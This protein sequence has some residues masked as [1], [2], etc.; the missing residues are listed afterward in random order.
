MPTRLI[1]EGLRS[2]RPP[3][4]SMAVDGAG[5]MGPLTHAPEVAGLIVQ[6]IAAVDAE[7]RRRWRPRGLADVLRAASRSAGAMA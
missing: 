3:A 1:A 5:H 2:C 7:V 6:H 4:G